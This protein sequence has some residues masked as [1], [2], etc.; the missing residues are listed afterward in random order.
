MAGSE[1]VAAWFPQVTP[2]CQ[3]NSTMPEQM[4]PELAELSGAQTDGNGALLVV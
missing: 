2:R 4:K 1:R 3:S